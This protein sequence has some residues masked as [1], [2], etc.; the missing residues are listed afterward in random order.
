VLL[1]L[2][3]A[4]LASLVSAPLGTNGHDALLT[5]SEAAKRLKLGKACLYKLVRAG[6]LPKVAGLGKEVRIPASA[7]TATPER[8]P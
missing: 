8:G 6:K 2:L 5:V 3:Q 1:N 7:L 4:R